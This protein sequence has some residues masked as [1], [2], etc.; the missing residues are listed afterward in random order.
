[1]KLRIRNLVLLA[2]AFTMMLGLTPLASA[3]P[4][5][6]EILTFSFAAS[7]QTKHAMIDN[8]GEPGLITIVA[9][10]GVDLKNQKLV[11][12]ITLPLGASINP[13][14]SEPQDF[15]QLVRY[16]VSIWDAEQPQ[17]KEYLVRVTQ[18]KHEAKRAINS[19]TLGGYEGIV[20]ELNKTILV[21]VPVGFDI[22]ALAPAISHNGESILP[23]VDAKQDFAQPV[24]YEITMANGSKETYTVLAAFLEEA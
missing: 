3:D 17:T 16:T 19:F 20:N 18:G 10:D 12:Q 14:A 24:S 11:P 1:M 22:S 7:G 15:S 4:V 6:C 21:D 8:S 5:E 13:P 2:V 9:P 23:A